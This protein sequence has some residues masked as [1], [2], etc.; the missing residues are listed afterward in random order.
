MGT[1]HMQPLPSEVVLVSG[2]HPTFFDHG[3]VRRHGFLDAPLVSRTTALLPRFSCRGKC[4]GRA[5]GACEA[6]SAWAS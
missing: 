1:V 5:C 4:F 3:S 6:T 2:Q